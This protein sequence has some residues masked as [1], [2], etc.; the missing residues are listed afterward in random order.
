MRGL[1]W[2]KHYFPTEF[3][4]GYVVGEDERTLELPSHPAPRAERCL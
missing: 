2:A 1:V 3:F 4:E